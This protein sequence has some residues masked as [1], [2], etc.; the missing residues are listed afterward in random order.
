MKVSWSEIRY[1]PKKFLLIELLIV[2]MMFMV[3][4]YQG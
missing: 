1:Q 2:L 3:I 4:F